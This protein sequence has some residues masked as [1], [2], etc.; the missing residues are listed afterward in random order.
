MEGDRLPVWLVALAALFW[1]AMVTWRWSA[2]RPEWRFVAAVSLLAYLAMLGLQLR[3][4]APPESNSAP[5]L[6]FAGCATA[7]LACGLNSSQLLLTAWLTSA[8]LVSGALVVHGEA[9]DAAIILIFS[10]GGL[11]PWWFQRVDGGES[12]SSAVAEPTTNPAPLASI[13]ALTLLTVGSSGAIHAAASGEASGVSPSGRRSTLPR[14]IVSGTK[15]LTAPT[16]LPA[17]STGVRPELLGLVGILCFAGLL[18]AHGETA[19]S[20]ADQDQ[21]RVIPA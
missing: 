12:P 15:P 21:Q 19:H 17:P 1:G 6:L 4:P 13:V 7:A 10:A 18:G 5:L 2:S 8:I 9:P 11:L 16:T 20:P 14:G 3:L